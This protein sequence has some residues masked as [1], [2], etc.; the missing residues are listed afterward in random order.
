MDLNNL[1]YLFFVLF[2]F[3]KYTAFSTF[4]WKVGLLLHGNDD[5][6]SMLNHVTDFANF[7]LLYG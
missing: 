7:T 1:C 2:C 3:Q 6:K 4:F 5:V